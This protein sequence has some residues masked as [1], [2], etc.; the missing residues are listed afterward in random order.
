MKSTNVLTNGSADVG[1]TIGASQIA[2]DDAGW[3]YCIEVAASFF[4]EDG[5]RGSLELCY[6]NSSFNLGATP[7][8]AEV[9]A[10]FRGSIRSIQL[11]QDQMR[12]VHYGRAEGKHAGSYFYF[13]VKNGKIPVSGVN[14]LLNESLAAQPAA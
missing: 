4:A 1:G 5:E 8:I 6:V 7:T 12:E 10:Y 14:V 11:Q 2:A 13:W 9:E 3:Y